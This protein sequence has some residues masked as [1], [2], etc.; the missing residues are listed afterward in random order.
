M[1]SA[2]VAAA[3]RSS[4]DLDKALGE[5][6]KVQSIEDI[7]AGF[8]GSA[9]KAF[10]DFERQAKERNRVAA[11]YSF[12]LV[13]LEEETGKQRKA[14]LETSI[15]GAV[16]GLKKLIED[17]ATGEKSSGTANDRRRALLAR[18]DG[19]KGDAASDPAKA[20]KLADVLD[21]LYSVSLDANGSAGSAF[22]SDRATINTTAQ[23]IIDQA[24]SE[25]TAAQSKARST[26]GTDQASTD[27]LIAQSNKTLADIAA[28]GNDLYG[29]TAQMLAQ[30]RTLGIGGT[31]YGAYLAA[32][33][34]TGAKVF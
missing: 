7:L 8:A 33:Q 28:T 17:L 24:T 29:L 3:L 22:T 1:I 15:D 16:G 12:D 5:A 25:I 9:R 18:A 31:G 21:Q 11:K 6:L 2:K 14:L 26:A 23:S 13:K 32:A 27:A 34:N 10:I 4:T 20:S 19:L 30:L